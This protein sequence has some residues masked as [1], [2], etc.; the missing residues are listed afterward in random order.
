MKIKNTNHNP[1]LEFFTFFLILTTSYS[2][3]YVIYKI[4][5]YS[6]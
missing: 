1:I 2:S 5:H 3:E 4:L 6:I